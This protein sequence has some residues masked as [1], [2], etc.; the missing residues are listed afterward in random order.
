[1]EVLRNDRTRDGF[2]RL[3]GKYL[4][5]CLE[6]L[7]HSLATLDV[8]RLTIAFFAISGL[9]LLD[10]LHLIEPQKRDIIEWIYSLQ[11]LVTK[12]N[13]SGGHCGRH[14]FRGSAANG[15]DNPYD[16]GNLA[17]TY[18]ALSSLLILGDDL[19][20]VDKKKIIDGLKEHQLSDGSFVPVVYEKEN[21]MRF[22]YCA[23]TVSYI[24]N[25]W[26]A[27]DRQKIVSFIRNSF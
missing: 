4:K 6:V 14:G 12:N 27:I 13:E 9:D 22:V 18:C 10:C 3:H 19:K 24:L 2:N 8:S 7:P 11:I 5:R 16:C 23:T 25:D 1:M 21:D 26:S 20:R 17:M 15:M